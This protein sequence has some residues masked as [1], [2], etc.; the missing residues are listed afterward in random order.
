MVD[1]KPLLGILPPINEVAWS[2]VF[3]RYQ[4]FPEFKQLNWSMDLD[5]FKFIYLMEYA[6]RLLGRLIGIVYF[7]PMLYFIFIRKINSAL[8]KRLIMLL[9][10]GAIQGGMGWYMVKSGLVDQPQ[11]S[12][13]RLAAHLI[14]AVIIYG[15]ML[16]VL[17]GLIPALQ[18]QQPGTP[19]IGGIL[20]V[21]ILVMITSGGFVAGTHAGQIYNTFPKM[22]EF[23]VPDQINALI[24]AWRNI[25]ENQITIQFVHRSLAFIIMILVIV[26]AWYFVS[27]HK[28]RSMKFI[29]AGMVVGVLLQIGLGIAT[30]LSAVH[31]VLGV[32]HQ[33]GALLLLSSVVIAI[34]SSLH[35]IPH[36]V[37]S[38]N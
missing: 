12:Q 36:S 11:V 33:A 23:W 13:Y 34:S 21:L 28:H 16:R 24:P 32:S 7:F 19:V 10:F 17:V 4:Q 15:Y 8:T 35:P 25:F 1:W 38:T 6:H 18:M 29:A 31:P 20:L 30:L 9:I 26:Y 14:I 22:G 27:E 37:S 5:Q 2:E 3:A